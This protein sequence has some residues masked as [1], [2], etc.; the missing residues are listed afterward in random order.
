M[1][2]RC[3]GQRIIEATA[4]QFRGVHK[5]VEIFLD[6]DRLEEQALVAGF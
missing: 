4:I 5:S 3:V 2:G 6:I 1:V